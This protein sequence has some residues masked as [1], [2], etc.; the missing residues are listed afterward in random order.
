MKAATVC[1]AAVCF[2][3]ALTTVAISADPM[4]YGRHLSSECVT[5]HKI[6]GSAAGIPPITG[7]NKDEFVQTLKFYKEGLRENPAM[8]S[9]AESLD[10]TQMTAL[11]TYFGSLP[12]ST[13]SATSQ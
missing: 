10:E 3:T 6:D 12:K 11:A 1:A 9:V 7:W 5:C 4:A 8:R 13:R 2:A